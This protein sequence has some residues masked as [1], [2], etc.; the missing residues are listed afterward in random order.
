MEL[1]DR[2]IILRDSG[3]IDEDIYQKSI[4]IISMF[5]TKWNI[6]LKEENGAML[7][8]HLCIALQR[9][10]NNSKVEEI[11]E[12]I[13]GEVKLNPNFKTCKRVLEDIKSEINMDIPENEQ[14]FIVMHLCVLF[15]K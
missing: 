9:A 8:T 15:N 2:L 3:Q 11:D 12:E 14:S 5:N 7:I 10:K 4:R 13:Y 6:E 1:D